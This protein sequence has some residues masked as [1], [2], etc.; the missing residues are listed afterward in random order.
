MWWKVMVNCYAKHPGSDYYE[1]RT[2][3]YG[4]L[5]KGKTKWL[6]PSWPVLIFAKRF[7]YQ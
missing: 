5:I 7:Y 6:F 2:F 3:W 1:G 4:L